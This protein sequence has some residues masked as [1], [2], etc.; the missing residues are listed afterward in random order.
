MARDTLLLEWLYELLQHWRVAGRFRETE[1][2]IVFVAQLSTLD[3]T[4][5]AVFTTAGMFSV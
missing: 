2:R 4:F 1:L 5:L 3:Q